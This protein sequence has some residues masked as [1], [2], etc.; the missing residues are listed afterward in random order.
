MSAGTNAIKWIPELSAED[1]SAA[2]R[3]RS[4]ASSVSKLTEQAL[5]VRAGARLAHCDSVEP[6]DAPDADRRCQWCGKPLSAWRR[7]I[8]VG[9]PPLCSRNCL[10]EWL[11]R[12]L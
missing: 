12:E 5:P 6:N 1:E 9:V 10:R 7:L 2:R 3:K 8:G 4:E 11:A